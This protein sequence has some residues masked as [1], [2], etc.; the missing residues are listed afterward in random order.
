MS[1]SERED[2]SIWS[3]QSLIFEHK[4]LLEKAS[5]LDPID[6]NFAYQTRLEANKIYAALYDKTLKNMVRERVDALLFK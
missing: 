5:K 2:Y 4:K 6:S 1:E 3:E